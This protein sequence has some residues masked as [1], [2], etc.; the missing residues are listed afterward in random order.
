MFGAGGVLDGATDVLGSLLSGQAFS[1]P[2]A[3]LGTVIKG[4][5]TVKNAK[6]LTKEGLRQ[7]GFNLVTGAITATTGVNVNGVANILFPKNN[8]A[9]QNQ[10]TAAALTNQTRSNGPLDQTKV[11]TFFDAR[12]GALTSL[13][14]NTVFQKSIGVGNLSEINS[15]WNAL[16]ASAKAAYEAQ[17]LEAVANG[18]PEVQSQYNLI[19]RQG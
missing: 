4:A 16:S 11:K 10:S 15:R 5:N 18:A 1:S 12:P 13:A 7:E 3:L 6:K 2:G 17:A 8:G 19:K 9:G 14:K